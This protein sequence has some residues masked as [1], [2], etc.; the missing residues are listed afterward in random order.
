[1][2]QATGA[3]SRATHSGLQGNV[4]AITQGLCARHSHNSRSEEQ[5]SKESRAVSCGEGV[6]PRAS[7]P[8]CAQVHAIR[9]EAADGMELEEVSGRGARVK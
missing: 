2:P 9:I 7:G 3:R 5:G 6:V 4:S 1:M 8:L